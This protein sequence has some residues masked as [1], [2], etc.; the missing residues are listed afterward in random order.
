MAIVNSV[1][2]YA[3]VGCQLLQGTG[4]ALSGTAQQTNNLPTSGSISPNCCRGYVRV[5]IYNGGGTSPTVVDILT[6]ATDGTNT[7]TMDNY[8]P[9][10]A[11]VLS[12][13]SYVDFLADIL[14]DFAAT[15][16][17]A[18][19]CLLNYGATI[20]KCL[21]TLGGTSPTATLDWEIAVEP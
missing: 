13:T 7:V 20:F 11:T 5:K 3:G 9:G 10:T 19:G 17:G 1:A 2:T 6:T 14:F 21:T 8:H 12:T 4:I 16:G 18:V 15:A